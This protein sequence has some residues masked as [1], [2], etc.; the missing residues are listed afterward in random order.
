MNYSDEALNLEAIETSAK[1]DE[2]KVNTVS[3][4]VLDSCEVA[5]K[6]V[7][8][9]G[10]GKYE[11]NCSHTRSGVIFHQQLAG[12]KR[13]SIRP[14]L[15]VNDEGAF[16]APKHGSHGVLVVELS[17]NA[18]LKVEDGRYSFTIEP[19]FRV[20]IPKARYDAVVADIAKNGKK[21][22]EEVTA[23]EVADAVAP[24]K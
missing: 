20:F 14:K 6:T 4:D 17:E 2:K 15:P 12:G 13:I 24:R 1:D 22:P 5:Q 7:Y 18:Q 19:D 11:L 23:K 16:I 8:V 10:K 3:L 9:V 21:K